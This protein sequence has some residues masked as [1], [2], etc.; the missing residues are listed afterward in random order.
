MK[1]ARDTQYGLHATV[2]TRD[3]DKA[4]QVARRCPAARCRSTA[5]RR[6]T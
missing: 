4:F 5:S 2:F 3:I 1:I 6:A